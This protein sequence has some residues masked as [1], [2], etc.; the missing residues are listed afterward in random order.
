MTEQA[1]Q[2]AFSI[3]GAMDA[4]GN[5]VDL[6]VA[7]GVFVAE[8]PEG[9]ELIEADGLVV[10]PGFV[11]IHT[12]LREPGFEA[13]ETIASG[14]AAAVAG[15]YTAVCAM[16]NTD[17]VTDSV[18][19]VESMRKLARTSAHNEVFPIG[20]LTIDLAGQQLS[21]IAEM[22]ACGVRLFSDDGRCLMDPVLMRRALELSAAHNVVIAQHSQDHR[23][24]P[25]DA[26]ADERSIAGE[27][28]LPGWPWAAESSIIAR[29]VQLAELTGGHLHVCH[30]STA[31][32]VEVVR[33]AKARGVDVT[34]EATPHH[35]LLTSDLLRSGS[36][37]YKVNPPLRS[38]EDVEAV[39]AGLVDRTID[40]VGTDHAPHEAQFKDLP[41]PQAKPGMTALEQALSS[42]ME[43]LLLPG[44]ID[45]TD[46]T[47]IMSTA[48]AHR[49]Q[50][51]GQGL[52]LGVGSPANLVL[53]HPARR[54]V[55]NR[56]DSASAGR[57]NP[58]H[59]MDL[60]DPIELTMGAGRILYR[61]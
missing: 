33:W 43:S 31:E 15:G 5:I 56:D 49:G 30:L 22:A 35:M 17:P 46:V 20:S 4:V 47:R 44:R 3:R 1:E 8:A 45:W 14:T 12:H 38:A 51:P 61:R 25:A 26:C 60:P 10:L 13:S 7:R 58:Y 9:S 6:H 42:L 11:D 40:L 59:G 48:P 50:V 39:R 37:D 52:G 28:G 18:E 2:K 29:D 54:R 41:F 23:L 24:A 19:R 53:V 21:P 27:L 34:A 32:S 55:V 36:T 16:A 57:N